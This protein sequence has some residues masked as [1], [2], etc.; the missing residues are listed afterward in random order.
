METRKLFVLA[1]SV[2]DANDYIQ[3]R[4]YDK[5]CNPGSTDL[6]LFATE[7][8]AEK[9]ATSLDIDDDIYNTAELF[10]GELTDEEIL[11]LTGYETIEEFDEALAEPYS[12]DARVKNLGEDEKGEVAQAIV[13]DG[14]LLRDVDCPNYDFDKSLE[15]AIL[16][17][18]SWERYIGYARKFIEIRRAD[19]SD[20]ET[21][22]TKEDK[23]FATQCDVLLTADEVSEAGED[24]HEAMLDR[25]QDGS[26]KWQNERFMEQF[27]EEF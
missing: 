11:E 18:W 17:F 12:T 1:V 4:D 14:N 10:E 3:F 21:I 26:W 13:D 6:Y 16:V 20:T 22:L 8:E 5:S 7:E 24:L 25:L 9:Y 23:V 19:G 15:G 27:V 2:W